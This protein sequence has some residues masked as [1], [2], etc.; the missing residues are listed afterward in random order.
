M[1]KKWR[2]KVSLMC[3]YV[4]TYNK[5]TYIRK[6]MYA[7]TVHTYV[8]TTISCVHYVTRFEIELKKEMFDSSATIKI[9]RERSDT[10]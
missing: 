7:A 6:S 2:Q 10:K 4:W 8:I 1:R 3:M 9:P 5:I